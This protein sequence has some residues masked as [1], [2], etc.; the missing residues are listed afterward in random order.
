VHPDTVIGPYN[1]TLKTMTAA[2]RRAWAERVIGKLTQRLD[3]GDEVIIL[4]GQRYR[5][6]LLEPL[7]Q[8]RCRFQIPMQGLRFGQQ[9]AWLNERLEG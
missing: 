2:A 4:A 9:L 3:P 7:R 1:E 8:M 6:G 5:A